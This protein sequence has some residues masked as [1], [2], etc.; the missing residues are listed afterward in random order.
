M[1]E[2]RPGIAH[3]PK[4][5]VRSLIS[6]LTIGLSGVDSEDVSGHGG[7]ALAL[8]TDR[9]FYRSIVQRQN[10]RVTSGARW[11]DSTWTYTHNGLVAQSGE[12]L[13]CKQEAV[14]S[15]L[16]LSTPRRKVAGPLPRRDIGSAGPQRCARQRAAPWGGREDLAVGRF[17]PCW[18]D[19]PV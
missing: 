18:P 2:R 15:I 4:T 6:L 11:S 16:T 1:E 7:G 9:H 10:A 12:R 3:I 8:I 19:S 17:D 5:Q 13:L 14:S